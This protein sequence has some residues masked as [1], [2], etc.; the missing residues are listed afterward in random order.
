MRTETATCETGP[1]SGTLMP[2]WRTPD[3]GILLSTGPVE[4]VR[5]A[6]TERSP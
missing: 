3:C 6:A 2:L 5:V 4:Y 1:E